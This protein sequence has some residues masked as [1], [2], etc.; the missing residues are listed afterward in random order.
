MTIFRVE[1]MIILRLSRY[2]VSKRE[3]EMNQEIDRQSVKWELSLKANLSIYCLAL[4]RPY[5]KS[6]A[7]GNPQENE[8]TSR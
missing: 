2:Q 6:Q 3:G 4:F 7:L 5:P 8:M 1:V